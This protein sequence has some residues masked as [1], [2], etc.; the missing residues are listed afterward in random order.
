MLF[1]RLI[2]TALMAASLA[3]CGA[4]SA[5]EEPSPAKLALHSSAALVIDQDT[6]RVLYGKNATNIAPI[7]SI[8][9]LMTAM[10]VL[11]ANLDPEEQIAITEDDV[12]WLRGSRS[13]LKPGTVLTRDEMLRLALMASEN[14]AAS[15]LGRAYPGGRDAFIAAMN[16][17]AQ[18][19]GMAGTRYADSTGLSSTNV[20][21]AEDL[22]TLVRA[23]HRYPKVRDYSTATNFSV[24]LSGRTSE[25]HNTNRL[26]S[27]PTWDI[28]VSK[29]G[30]INEAGRCLVMQ[31]AFAG[32]NVVI[33]LL[34]S[35]GKLS[36]IGDAT[37]IRHWLEGTTEPVAR[38]RAPGKVAK[39]GA[40]S[41][42]KQVKV[43][44]K[45]QP[46]PRVSVTY[47]QKQGP[48]S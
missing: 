26:V 28:G 9:K 32:R 2:K 10:V 38:A 12:D 30:F 39:S 5:N 35:W 15:A 27:N 25:F 33:V 24:N 48:R 46:K 43:A 8:T 36:R 31:A 20:S 41:G 40:K 42:A 1:R 19:L 11:D 45:G 23:A 17:K 21:T 14:R 47:S 16:Q 13:R 3:L 4:A 7:A 6:G 37:R 29:T 18:M 22:A 34:D 44:R